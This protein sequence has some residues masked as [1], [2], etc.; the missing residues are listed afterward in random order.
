MG[1]RGNVA[2]VG[3]LAHRH[4]QAPR[5]I[6]RIAWLR[7]CLPQLTCW[8]WIWICVHTV[9]LETSPEPGSLCHHFLDTPRL[10]AVSHVSHALAYALRTLAPP[11]Q[12]SKC[13]K[14]TKSLRVGRKVAPSVK[15]ASALK[16]MALISGS[17]RGR[18]RSMKDGEHTKK[19]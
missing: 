6:D 7:L 2:K 10:V 4:N 12:Y 17:A 3:S 18:K 8:S 1:C 16:T 9:I 14:P 13:Q 15:V 11:L 5:S 19:N